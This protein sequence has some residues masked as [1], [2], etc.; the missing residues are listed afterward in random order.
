MLQGLKG[1]AQFISVERGLMVFM[2]AVGAAFLIGETLAWSS[3]LYLGLIAFCGWSAVDAINNIFDVDSD[4]L[5]DPFRAQFTKKL[6]RFGLPIAAVFTVLSL[7][8]GAVTLLPYVLLFI[9]LGIGFGV[10]Y[11]APLFRLKDTAY[12]PI[13]NVTVGAIPVMIVAAFFN[14]FSLNVLTLICLIG[15][16]TSI[17]SLWEDLADFASDF[18][19]GS[20]TITVIMGFRH[21]LI[22]AVIMG[23]AMI[24]LAILIGIL[25]ELP[26]VYYAALIGLASLMTIRIYRNRQILLN[27]DKEDTGELFKLGKILA[28][29]FVI[30]AIVFTLAL[31]L[32]SLFKIIIL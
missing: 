29:D 28:K 31:M 26:I 21:G 2:I 11:S 23:Y 1:F 15:V 27:K 20:H 5:S 13:V 8:L 7:A 12:K 3:A 16:T 9:A 25:F 17:N 6:G 22:F 30:V 19:R 4:V 18:N 10:L 14:V 32:S 24:P